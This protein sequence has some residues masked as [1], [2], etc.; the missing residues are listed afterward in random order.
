METL[1]ASVI[2]I[3]VFILASMILNNL[4]SNT[5]KNDKRAINVYLNVLEYKYI[6]NKIDLPFFDDFKNWQISLTKDKEETRTVSLSA[7]HKATNK[8]IKKLIREHE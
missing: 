5:I 2:I 8:Q 7:T 4:F 3:T 1:V 6:N